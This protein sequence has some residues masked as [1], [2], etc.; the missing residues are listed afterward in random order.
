[1][2]SRSTVY[3]DA[4]LIET[5]HLTDGRSDGSPDGLALATELGLTAVLVQGAED[6]PAD[7]ASAWHLTAE[8][9]PAG[10]PRWSRTV[11]IGPRREPGRVAV[12]GLRSARDLR[13]ALLE[14]ASEA[15]LD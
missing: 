7:L 11:L 15:A 2:T 9:P 1:V 3:I 8:L 12:T 10:S 14:L 6:L 13:V 4:G 5:D